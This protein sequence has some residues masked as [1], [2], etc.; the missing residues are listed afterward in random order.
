MLG[1]AVRQLLRR[2]G[3]GVVSAE[4]GRGNR[5]G[6]DGIHPNLATEQFRRQRP[7]QRPQRRLARRIDTAVRHTLAGRNRRVDDNRPAVLE[8]RQR[9]L[10]GKKAPLKFMSK[11]S[12][13]IA[14]VVCSKGANLAIPALANSA[15]MEPHFFFVR[16]KR[17]SRSPS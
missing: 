15:S 2:F 4:D 17:S 6:G 7:G 11:I 9:L 3:G 12:S 10:D 8:Q 1:E 14:S 5:A 16:A 13:C